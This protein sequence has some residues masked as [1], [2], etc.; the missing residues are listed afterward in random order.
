MYILS[1][2]TV[3]FL[4]RYLKGIDVLGDLHTKIELKKERA[5]TIFQ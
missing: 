3:P 1:N 4:V 5:E 2:L